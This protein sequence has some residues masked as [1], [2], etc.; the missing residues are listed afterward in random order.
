MAGNGTQKETPAKLEKRL[1]TRTEYLILEVLS[2]GEPHHRS[3]LHS[4]LWDDGGALYNVNQHIYNLNRKLRPLGLD[5]VSIYRNRRSFYRWMRVYR[6][7]DD[8]LFTSS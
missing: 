7:Q 1:F 6:P 3:E 8:G 4:C 5:I 2:D